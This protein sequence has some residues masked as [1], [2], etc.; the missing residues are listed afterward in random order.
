MQ[1]C[2]HQLRLMSDCS[3]LSNFSI[4]FYPVESAVDPARDEWQMLLPI[5]ASL[6]QSIRNVR[7]NLKLCR[8]AHF[9]PSIGEVELSRRFPALQSDSLEEELLARPSL[10]SVVFALDDPDIREASAPQFRD[11]IGLSAGC[12]EFLYNRFLGLQTRGLL[13]V[14]SAVVQG[15]Y[16][17]D[18]F[19]SFLV[20]SLANFW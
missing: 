3:R 17:A 13:H 16:P 4:T 1:F 9:D 7:A 2:T 10:V 20:S 14:E 19:G 18:P 8:M 6:P 5:I 11:S 12:A 15:S